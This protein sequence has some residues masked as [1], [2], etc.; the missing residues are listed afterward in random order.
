[1]W[2]YTPGFPANVVNATTF[3]Q[4]Y[5]VRYILDNTQD[6]LIPAYT[7]VMNTYLTVRGRSLCTRA[8]AQAA[9]SLLDT[10]LGWGAECL[11]LGHTTVAAVRQME[12]ACLA[13]ARPDIWLKEVC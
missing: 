8:V 12:N 1:M 2:Q 4:W 9:S 7:Q 6:I 13:C 11:C 5:D 3:V 10:G